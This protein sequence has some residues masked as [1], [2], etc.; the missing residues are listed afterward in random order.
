MSKRLE[1]IL[2]E[3]DMQEIQVISR[4]KRMTVSEWVRTAIRAAKANEPVVDSR[5]KLQALRAAT[6]H[7]FPS[8]DIEEMLAQIEGG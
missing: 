1:V 2:E 4:R 5:R 8:A 7:S 3:S 6:A